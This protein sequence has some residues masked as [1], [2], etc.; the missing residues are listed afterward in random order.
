MTG[1]LG[2]KIGMTQVFVGSISTPVTV[3]E[4]GPCRVVGIK[5]IEKNGYSAIA[6]SFG[7]KSA[8]QTSKAM[9]TV[10]E[11][12]SSP[13]SAIVR[14][15]RID[16]VTKFSLG[17]EISVDILSDLKFVD[18]VG[19]SKGKGFQ[20]VVKRHGFAGGPASHGSS[21][22][23]RGPGSIGSVRGGSGRVFP[24]K[25]MAGHM[26]TD[27]VTVQNLAVVKVDRENNCLLVKGAVPGA[28]NGYVMV[29]PALKKRSD[30]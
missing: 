1:I 9:K 4:V 27:R 7:R 22:F 5:T 3:L 16:D 24:G 26:G 12:G 8:N 23:H 17:Q 18:V 11:K 10:F 19:V 28:R 20:G 30:A 25:R 14:E 29:K 15:F 21:L 6:L 2:K 13:I